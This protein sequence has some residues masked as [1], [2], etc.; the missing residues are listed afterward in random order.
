MK[1]VTE[2][3]LSTV[4][5]NATVWLCMLWRLQHAYRLHRYGLEHKLYLSSF[6][7]D[8][9]GS[10]FLCPNGSLH[11]FLHVTDQFV[12]K[13]LVCVSLTAL[14]SYEINLC[15]WK[16]VPFL[17]LDITYS[18]LKLYSFVVIKLLPLHCNCCLQAVNLS[19][20]YLLQKLIVRYR[21]SYCYSLP[22]RKYLYQSGMEKD[23]YLGH[24]LAR[25]K[26]RAGKGQRL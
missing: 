13:S 6:P 24:Y 15:S 21:T 11:N 1:V 18:P 3:I 23:L 12:V 20:C 25:K 5:V 4:H 9:S 22:I 19:V 14:L 16:F 10:N 17:L 8:L 26:W 2:V 7:C